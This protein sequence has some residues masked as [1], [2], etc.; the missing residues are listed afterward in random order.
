MAAAVSVSAQDK[1]TLAFAE[2]GIF[3]A[4][5]FSMAD[6]SVSVNINGTTYTGHF[7]EH[8][9]SFSVENG[10]PLNTNDRNSSGEWGRA[11]LFA[12]SSQ[13]LQCRLNT[14]FPN[15]SGNC[16]DA[17]GRQFVIASASLSATTLHPAPAT[18]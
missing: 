9:G 13:I 7:A 12:S 1:G 10:Q 18:R 8:T 4:G 3:Y 2:N 6:R 14:G 11:F 5:N 17:S 16:Q 15:V